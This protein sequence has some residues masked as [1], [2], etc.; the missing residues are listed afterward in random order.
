MSRDA[1]EA[2]DALGAAWSPNLDAYAAGEIDAAQLVCVVCTSAPCTCPV[3]EERVRRWS[4]R[5][6]RR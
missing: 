3:P 2:V 5:G 4:G 1:I 6:D